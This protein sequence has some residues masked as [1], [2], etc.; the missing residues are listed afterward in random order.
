MRRHVSIAAALVAAVLIAGCSDGSDVKVRTRESPPAV[1]VQ[2]A[3]PEAHA[4]SRLRALKRRAR[5]RLDAARRTAFRQGVEYVLRGLDVAPGQDYAIAFAQGRRGFFVK[6][7]LVMKPGYFYECPPQ[8]QYCNATDT[9]P[10][11]AT[12]E[13]APADPCDPHYPNV[14]LDP[15]A[16]DYD[17]AGSGEDGPEYVD[18]P[19]RILGGDPFGLDGRPRDEIGCEAG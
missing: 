18:G 8:S 1:R 19:V 17:C 10:S 15:T 7:F 14:C 9:A 5:L 6:D 13:P 12:L 16:S 4:D 3:A 11:S 2:T